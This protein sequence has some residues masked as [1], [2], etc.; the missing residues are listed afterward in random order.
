[1]KS[2]M[3]IETI[4]FTYESLFENKIVEGVHIVVREVLEA[5]GQLK[6]VALILLL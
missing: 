1:M 3:R 2:L 4:V 6:D 5:F